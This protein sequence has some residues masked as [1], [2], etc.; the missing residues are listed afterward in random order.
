MVI[1]AGEGVFGRDGGPVGIQFFS[2][3]LGKAGMDTLANFGLADG[4]D[5]LAIGGNFDKGV[6]FEGGVGAAAGYTCH[7]IRELQRDRQ[8]G[9]NGPCGQE[10]S[11]AREEGRRFHAFSP[12][13]NSAA[14]ALMAFLIRGYVPQRQMFPDI[15]ASISSSDG[16]GVSMIRLAAD[17]IWPGWQ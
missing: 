7:G 17:M 12:L 13:R 1:I 11:A 14:A 2:Q 4:D 8:S 10:E 3:R 15:A 9:G 6:W 5:D 16:S